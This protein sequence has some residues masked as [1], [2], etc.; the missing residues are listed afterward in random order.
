MDRANLKSRIL[1]RLQTLPGVAD[2]GHFLRLVR[3]RRSCHGAR[4]FWQSTSRLAS[5]LLLIISAVLTPTVA[6]AATQV[7]G[8]TITNVSIYMG[9][10]GAQGAYVLFSPAAPG[11]EGCSN[12]S[13]NEIW[14]DFAAQT[15]PDGKALYATVLAA[16]LAGR[17]MTFGV[18]GCALSGQV[19][20][21]YRV[22]VQPN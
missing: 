12:P 21:I 14:I 15:S 7:T 1:N 20:L 22:D 9:N 13:G 19:P 2:M 10:S 6:S 8:V 17:S 4:P 3:T 18:S 11:L 16:Y 5:R